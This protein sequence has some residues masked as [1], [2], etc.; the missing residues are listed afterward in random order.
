VILSYPALTVLS[1]NPIES[2]NGWVKQ[3][4]VSLNIKRIA[5]SLCEYLASK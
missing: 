4:R 2:G 3:C 5:S 1:A